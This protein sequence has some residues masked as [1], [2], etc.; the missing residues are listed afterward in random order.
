MAKSKATVQ[1]SN[2]TGH[3]HHT[4]RRVAER[5]TPRTLE[6]AVVSLATTGKLA[7]A[8]R[9]AIR[10]QRKA[11]LAITYKKGNQI[12]TEYPDGRRVV[13]RN[14]TPPIYTIPKGVKRLRSA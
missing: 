5:V 8:A 4:P 12:V 7:E 11:G 13:L 9:S 1:S 3:R 2:G 6:D 14:L 10:A